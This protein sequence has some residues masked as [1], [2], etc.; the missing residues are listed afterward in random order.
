MQTLLA[1]PG[2]LCVLQ[3]EAVLHKPLPA[4]PVQLTLQLG[5]AVAAAAGAAV[6]SPAIPNPHTNNTADGALAAATKPF[7]LMKVLLA[8][9]S[10]NRARASLSKR[11]TAG[12]LERFDQPAADR[13]G[14]QPRASQDQR[15]PYDSSW[16]V[17]GAAC[18]RSV[19]PAGCRAPGGPAPGEPDR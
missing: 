5:G 19:L 18:W 9:R 16:I 8:E 14:D 17:I 15:Y 1:G 11:N 3:F 2:T 7:T 12:T 6:P 10:T 4:F 13:V